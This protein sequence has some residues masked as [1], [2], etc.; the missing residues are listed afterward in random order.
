MLLQT[1]DASQE[2][3]GEIDGF[4]PGTGPA[5]PAQQAQQS[6]NP[7]QRG[8]QN[9]RRSH[10]VGAEGDDVFGDA[11]DDGHGDGGNGDPIF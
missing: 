9:T 4:G 5:T 2:R 1:A 7:G 10:Q 8:A 6:R 3:G 11:M